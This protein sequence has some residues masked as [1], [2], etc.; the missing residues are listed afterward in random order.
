ME[1][2]ST[3]CGARNLNWG[4]EK[5]NHAFGFQMSPWVINLCHRVWNT[6]DTCISGIENVS[7][8]EQER[9]YGF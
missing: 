9:V 8:M 1:L 2:E 7:M 3:R 6:H 4:A 5:R